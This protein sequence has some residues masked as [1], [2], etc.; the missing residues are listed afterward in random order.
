MVDVNDNR[1]S[2]WKRVFFCV[3]EME[4]RGCHRA[5]T[6]HWKHFTCDIHTKNP[7]AAPLMEEGK[8]WGVVVHFNAKRWKMCWK[9]GERCLALGLLIGSHAG[10]LVTYLRFPST[11]GSFS[12]GEKG[13]EGDRV[14]VGAGRVSRCP[15]QWLPSFT[16]QEG[17]AHSDEDR[18]NKIMAICTQESNGRR[19]GGGT[20]RD[21]DQWE[22]P[23]LEKSMLMTGECCHTL[24]HS[25]THPSAH[26]CIH[27]FKGHI[28]QLYPYPVLRGT[29]S[30]T[31]YFVF[32]MQA[33]RAESR[34]VAA[35][36][37]VMTDI[38]LKHC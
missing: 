26:A 12:G 25:D 24:T 38:Q 8:G 17:R 2:R 13:G 20:E 6:S 11:E 19:G 5:V 14:R 23:L 1:H 21:G 27:N 28:M 3:C 22:R 34:W 29:D 32:L 18:E 16:L 9:E 15:D 36:A 10:L 35:A 37:V 33:H 30:H 31:H 4:T 7:P